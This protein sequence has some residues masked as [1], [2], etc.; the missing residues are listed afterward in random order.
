MR[1]I[2]FRAWDKHLGIMLKDV[3]LHD[4]SMS[5]N[6]SIE[7]IQ[8]NG[9]I[10]Q[11]TGLKDRNSVEIYEGDKIKT[12]KGIIFIVKWSKSY[13]RWNGITEN[14]WTDKPYVGV[15]IYKS[16]PW[17]AERGEVIGNIYE[18]EEQLEVKNG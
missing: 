1:P 8:K 14:I 4:D 16:L 17:L 3:Y 11:Y 18:N 12:N 7:L 9:C 6:D 2:K 13:A 10:M 15:F 5:I